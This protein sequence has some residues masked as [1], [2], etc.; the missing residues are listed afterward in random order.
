MESSPELAHEVVA[1]FA[2]LAGGVEVD[3]W[4]HADTTRVAA[5]ARTGHLGR[6]LIPRSFDSSLR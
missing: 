4:L 3:G 2:V 5:I 1:A 6:I